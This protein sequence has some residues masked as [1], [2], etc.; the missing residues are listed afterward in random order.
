MTIARQTHVYTPGTELNSVLGYFLHTNRT[1][2][3]TNQRS[4]YVPY[5]HTYTNDVLDG[6][7][8]AVL[9]FGKNGCSISNQ[10][11]ACV[12]ARTGNTPVIF[13]SLDVDLHSFYVFFKTVDEPN[14]EKRVYAVPFTE[15]SVKRRLKG[16]YF[17][18]EI[19]RLLLVDVKTM[20]VRALGESA[21]GL[22]KGAFA[23]PPETVQSKEPKRKTSGTCSLL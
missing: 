4:S 7:D 17:V 22:E 1:E 23:A 9:F 21:V 18:K 13:V 14:L 20:D 5:K 8:S 12:H 19:G 11:R 10:L 2:Q 16:H 6:H 15:E 3:E